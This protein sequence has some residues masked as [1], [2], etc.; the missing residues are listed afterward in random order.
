MYQDERSVDNKSYISY[1]GSQYSVPIQYKNKQVDIYPTE[2]V[3][4]VYDNQTG[5]Q[6]AC[7][8]ISSIPGQRIKDREGFRE[9]TTKIHH[10]KDEV[11]NLIDDEFWREF[12]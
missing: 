10:L 9:T 8:S 3:L 1:S 5:I 4:F 11:K 2:Q 12:A 6:I 7:H